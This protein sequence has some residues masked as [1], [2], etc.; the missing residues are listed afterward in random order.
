MAQTWL[1]SSLVSSD[2]LDKDT[3]VAGGSIPRMRRHGRVA[4]QASWF[5]PARSSMRSS[6]AQIS[7][8]RPEITIRPAH[9]ASRAV[10]DS[11]TTRKGVALQPALTVLPGRV[12][13]A[14]TASLL[15]ARALV[16]MQDRACVRASLSPCAACLTKC[17]TRLIHGAKA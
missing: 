15:A 13:P 8:I 11:R 17:L 3:G 16:E 1:M 6:S 14:N 2:A 10:S 12:G 5:A 4:A 7:A 9:S